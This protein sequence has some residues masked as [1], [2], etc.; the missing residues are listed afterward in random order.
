MK[1]PIP[2]WK[3]P[4][5]FLVFQ[6]HF[7]R[8]TKNYIKIKLSP[9]TKDC[10]ICINKSPLKIMKNV[11]HCLACLAFHACLCLYIYKKK[12]GVV[13]SYFHT[14]QIFSVL[15]FSEF[16][17]CVRV[18]IFYLFTPLYQ[19]YLCFTLQTSTHWFP[20]V[21][22]LSYAGMYWEIC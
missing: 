1:I 15:F 16:L 8:N 9:S 10:F 22:Q 14:N 21:G 13:I 4:F 18:C 5:S 17:V 6:C 20:N 12:G 7:T 2:S 11:F 19:Y 3:L